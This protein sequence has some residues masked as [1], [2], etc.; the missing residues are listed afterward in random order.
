MARLKKRQRDILAALQELGGQAS[1]RSIA[2][3][4]G[5]D[6]NGVSQSLGVL[7][8]GEYVYYMSGRSGDAIY[9]LSDKQF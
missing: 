2:Q 5:L 8:I 4:T 9:A 6:V 7:A 3:K 1:I